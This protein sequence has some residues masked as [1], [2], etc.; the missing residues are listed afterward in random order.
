[1]TIAATAPQ[2]QANSMLRLYHS[3]ARLPL[4]A[5]LFS[6]A[7]CIKAPYF[8]SIRPCIRQ[9]KPGLSEWEIKNRR[10]V[11]NHLGSVHALAMGNLAELCAGTL[12]EASLPAHLRW[13]PKGMQIEYLKKATTE[14]VATAE[15]ADPAALTSGNYEVEV[16]VKN[17]SGEAVSRALITMWLSEK[18]QRR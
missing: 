12:M 18:K 13:I 2:E 10:R 7:L 14:L 9:L 4:G 6:R 11:R 8:S 3:F 16:I 5:W 17:A 15:I 1:M